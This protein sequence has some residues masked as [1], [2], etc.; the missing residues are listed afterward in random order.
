VPR[1]AAAA[2]HSCFTRRA[3]ARS[4]HGAAVA[5]AAAPGQGTDSASPCFQATPAGATHAGK[6]GDNPPERDSGAKTP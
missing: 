3:V 4:Q 2:L 5:H 6:E 1:A